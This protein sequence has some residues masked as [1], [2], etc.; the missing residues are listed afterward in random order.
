MVR[1]C[2]LFIRRLSHHAIF[3]HAARLLAQLADK[4]DVCDD[5]SDMLPELTT[6]AFSRLFDDDDAMEVIYHSLGICESA[7]AYF[8]AE[9]ADIR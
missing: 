1:N 6:S 2:Y 5:F 8:C 7:C 9:V 4:D 3:A